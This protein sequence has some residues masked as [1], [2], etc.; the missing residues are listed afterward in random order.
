MNELQAALNAFSET[1]GQQIK[2]MSD[3]FS[4]RTNEIEQ[5][6]KEVSDAIKVLTA[7]PSKDEVMGMLKSEV[8][9]AFEALKKDN[10]ENLGIIRGEAKSQ[11]DYLL[12]GIKVEDGRDALELEILPCID[13]DK[14][15]PR[16]TYAIHNGGLFRSY[17][18]T[19]GIKGWECVVNGVADVAVSIEGKTFSIAVSLSDGT[20][21][22]T[23]KTIPVPEYKGVFR[24]D[25]KYLKGD[26]VSHGGGLWIATDDD[27]S[28]IP[29]QSDG[30][31]L[32]VKRGRDGRGLYE[33]AR[34]NGY[35]GTEKELLP[36]ILRGEKP[37]NVV[38]L[39]DG[40]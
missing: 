5:S 40:L 4:R 3:A 11:I 26:S 30:W 23:E 25:E 13:L 37:D 29:G 10:D 32:A 14:T 35:K 36:F 34:A 28:S 6:I 1:V 38:R 8:S 2:A 18:K 22:R 15:Y 12:E 16:G 39:T 17:Q 9:T 19:V 33:I 7:S 24:S 21:E 20:Q 31:Q 27:P